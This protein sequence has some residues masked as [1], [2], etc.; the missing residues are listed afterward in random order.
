MHIINKV[1]LSELKTRLKNFRR[2]MDIK[3]PKWQLSIIVSKI[4]Q[5]YFTGTM[6]NAILLIPRFDEAVYWV[7]KSYER[8]LEESLFSNI[9]T[10]RSFR[11][12]AKSVEKLPDEIYL[13]TGVLTL[14]MYHRL[15]RYFTFSRAI[16]V[17]SVIASVR[18]VKSEYEI[19]KMKQ[20]GK[21]HARVLEERVPELLIEGISEAE[22]GAKLYQILI[23]E[24][25][26]GIAR[27][28]MFD[29]EIMLGQLGFGESSIYPCYFDGPGG[30]YGMS[31]A[32]PLLGSRDRKLKKGDLVFVDA[33][34]GVD[35][36]HTDKTVTFMFKESL[37]DEAI[38]QHNRC[39]EIQDAIA[40]MLKPG[41][42]P[43][44]IYSEIMGSLDVEFLQNFMG[45]G[46]NSVKFLG[47]GIGLVIDEKPVIAKGF[48]EPLKEGMVIALEP[49]KAIK[50]VGLVG[51]ENTF[52]VT[53]EGG[54]CITGDYKGL[55]LIYNL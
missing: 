36:Y 28:S 26:H 14:D 23:E 44:K 40:S 13:E 27:F 54:K 8:T 5:Y 33:A 15:Q 31:P 51:I 50:G 7:R 32:V 38:K 11:D 53:H 24:G 18:A 41:A 43:S 29:T 34:C 9:K 25:H 48:D 39:V 42:I 37:P 1:P 20:S 52:V 35:G 55:R 45:Y 10:M 30:Y 4:N 47:H 22:F 6:Q 16:S 12:A 3:H 49:K 2:E 21:I 46:A 17:D 19:E